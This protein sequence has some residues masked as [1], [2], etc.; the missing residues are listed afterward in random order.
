MSVY[1]DPER[2]EAE[3]HKVLNTSW[4]IVCRSSEIPETGDHLVWEGHG[5][6]IVVTRRAD[7]K[8]TAFHNVCAHRGARLVPECGKGARRFTCRWH[9]WTYDHDG[10]VLGMPDRQDFAPWQVD[11]AKAASVEVD[12]WGGW[13]WAVLAGP[14][15]APPLLDYLGPEIIAD[16]GVY[17]MEDMILVDK[18]T[19]DL[20]CNWKVVVDGFNENYHAQALHTITPQ[21]VI[22]GREGTFFTLGEHAMMV[23]PFKNVLTRL[24]ETLDHQGLSICHYTIFPTSVFNNNPNHLQLFR[25]VPISVDKTRFETWEL[26]YRPDEGDQEYVDGVNAHWER[27]KK[28]VQEDVEIFQEWGAARRSSAQ[29]RVVLNDHEC[30]IAHFHRVVQARLD[31]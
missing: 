7:G 6:T 3:R 22:D 16:L 4:Q 27:L 19:W 2:F 21:D 29:K 15:V 10:N 18:L 8:A 31:A 14:G 23:M 20:D 1:T 30:K 11:G 24:K 26:Q 25:A 5:E 9:N 13:V 28:V 17:K 12:E